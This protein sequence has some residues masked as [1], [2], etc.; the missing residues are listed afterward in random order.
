MNII[1][2]NSMELHIWEKYREA[3][4]R[5]FIIYHRRYA[6]FIGAFWAGDFL[7]GAVTSLEDVV[8]SDTTMHGHIILNIGESRSFCGQIVKLADWSRDG[9]VI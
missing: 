8:S 1:F 9:M 5:N 6:W 4:M 2:G 7:V 3:A